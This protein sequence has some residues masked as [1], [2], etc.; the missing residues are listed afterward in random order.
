MTKVLFIVT[1]ADHWTLNDG[2]KH[3]TGFW[4]D[5][6]VLPHRAFTAAGFDITIASP[7]GA[8]PVVDQVSLAPH[9]VG[10]PEH[11]RELT[12]YL[13]ALNETLASPRR[14]EDV[15][16]DDYDMVF[17]PG[18]H[19]PMEDLA[20]HE[21]TGRILTTM[22][23]SGRTVVI[24]CHG[25][26]AMLAARHADGTWPF[27]GYRMT[28]FTNEEETI[29]GLARKAPWLLEDRLAAA[30]AQLENSVAL[31]PN[32]VVDRNLY[33]GQNPMSAAPLAERVVADIRSSNA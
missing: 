1:G 31:T 21:P 28:A 24:V 10:G 30:G 33:T 18:G 12:D 8:R 9:V 6:L 11:A 16:P 4:A 25:P 23:D 15:D 20:V 13:D 14:L 3:P 2:T 19:G 22:L 7:E 17:V 5:E 29:G 26:A 27:A 32:V